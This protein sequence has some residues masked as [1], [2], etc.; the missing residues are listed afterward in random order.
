VTLSHAAAHRHTVPNMKRP[1]C[2]AASPSY[3][4]SPDHMA[5][6]CRRADPH[7]GCRTRRLRAQWPPAR[8]AAT[9]RSLLRGA[10]LGSID[11]VVVT[12]FPAPALPWHVFTCENVRS[13][14]RGGRRR[15]RGCK[16]SPHHVVV[17]L[18]YAQKRARHRH[19]RRRAAAE[20][21]GAC[22]DP[23][24]RQPARFVAGRRAVGR[25]GGP[26]RC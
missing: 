8:L 12:R 23:R 15:L 10:Q 1:L 16:I 2:V 11:G 3:A 7:A 21:G 19:H 20:R 22:D 18:A 5:R 6:P 17:R 14:S 4:A 26:Y 25:T 24:A 13:Q 9:R